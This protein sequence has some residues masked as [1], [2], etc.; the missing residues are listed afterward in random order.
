MSVKQ[1]NIGG[2]PVPSLGHQWGEEIPK[3]DPNFLNYVQEL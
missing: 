1:L 2:R 3:R